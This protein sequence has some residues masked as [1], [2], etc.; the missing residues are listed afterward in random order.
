MLN[1]VESKRQHRLHAAGDARGRISRVVDQ[2]DDAASD[3]LELPVQC[4]QATL[5]PIH[6]VM[7]RNGDSNWQVQP[8]RQGGIHARFH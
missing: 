6:L 3:S 7:R 1:H 5:N 8:S 2:Q 4:C